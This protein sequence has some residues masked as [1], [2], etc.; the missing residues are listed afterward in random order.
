[1]IYKNK[2][3]LVDLICSLKEDIKLNKKFSKNSLMFV[4]NID[5]KK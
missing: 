1:M 2:K 3:E 5:W 4:K